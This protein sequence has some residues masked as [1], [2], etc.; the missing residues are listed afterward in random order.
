MKDYAPVLIRLILGVILI[1]GTQDNVFSWARMIEFEK[2]L[3]SRGVPFPLFAAILS[4]Y[5]QFICGILILLGAFTR[6]AAAVMVI[7]FIAAIFIA[8][9]TG[10][11]EPARLALCMLF[12]SASLVLTGPGKLALQKSA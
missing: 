7:N 8:H 5:A 3:A 2:F 12:M 9:L 6:Y 4:A 1:E 11:F 10:G